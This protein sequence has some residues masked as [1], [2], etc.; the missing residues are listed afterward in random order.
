MNRFIA[1]CLSVH[2]ASTA[3]GKDLQVSVT[4]G[5]EDRTNVVVSVPLS[6]RI[7]GDAK[8]VTVKD[9]D[10]KPVVAQLTAARLLAPEVLRRSDAGTPPPELVLL[11]PAV[12]AGQT[13]TLTATFSEKS[14]QP[15]FAWANN[16]DGMPEPSFVGRPVLSQSSPLTATF[17]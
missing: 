7:V 16:K 2:A 8:G 3:S 13:I 4:G 12:K 15:G 17:G 9:A 6:E 5:K 11:L 10:G 14:E 1:C